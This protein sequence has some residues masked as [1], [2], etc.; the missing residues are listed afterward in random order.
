MSG[1]LQGKSKNK[2]NNVVVEVGL[3]TWLPVGDYDGD[4][5]ADVVLYQEDSGLWYFLLS[6]SSWT[7]ASQKLGAQGYKA[8][9]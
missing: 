9:Q 2:S 4:G 7:L 5:T 8:V 1:I 3:S 6:N